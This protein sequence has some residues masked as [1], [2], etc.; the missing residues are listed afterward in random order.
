MDDTAISVSDLTKTFPGG[1]VAVNG[2]DFEVPKGAVYGLVGRNGAGK[3]TTLRLLMGLLRPNRGVARVLGRDLMTA[4]REIR[5]HVAYVSQTQQ[6]HADMTVGELCHYLSHFYTLW[7]QSYARQLSDRFDVDWDRQVGVMSGGEQRKV[8]IL[9]AFAARADVLLLDEPAAGL[10]PIARRQLIDEVVDV[11]SQKQRHVDRRH[12]AD[13]D[14][15]GSSQTLIDRS[16]P[17]VNRGASGPGPSV[18]LVR[19]ARRA[20]RSAETNFGGDISAVPAGRRVDALFQ[21]ASAFEF[22]FSSA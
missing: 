8:S 2:L 3:T 12:A 20:G 7:D 10:D 4:P 18:V 14:E 19:D 13:R 17:S 6:L 9:L 15:P 21:P 11:I 5:E 22:S 16:I 1:V